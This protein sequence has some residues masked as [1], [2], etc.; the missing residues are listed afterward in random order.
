MVVVRWWW[1]W[2]GG[3]GG[4]GGGKVVVAVFGL[5]ILN[6]RLW[7]TMTI[8]LIQLRPSPTIH[9]GHHTWI[10]RGVR[11]HVH[12]FET[13]SCD[14]RRWILISRVYIT[15]VRYT[16]YACLAWRIRVGIVT[17]FTSEIRGQRSFSC[18]RC[19]SMLVIRTWI[20]WLERQGE[21]VSTNAVTMYGLYVILV[22]YRERGEVG[23]VGR[24]HGKIILK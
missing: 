11:A 6:M 15:S 19:G 9:L 16:L 21:S 13:L 5:P 1:R 20:Y 12:I 3:D 7:I 14:V 10:T 2:C 23:D 8:E 17:G 18:F 24:Q 22:T 4:G